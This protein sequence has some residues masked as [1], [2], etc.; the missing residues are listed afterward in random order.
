MTIKAIETLYHG[1]KFRSRLEARW[2]VFFGSLGAR[3]QYEPQGFL[4]DGIPYLPDFWIPLIGSWAGP[5][6][7]G[8]PPEKGFW[9]EIKPT[10]P[11]EEELRL[12][13]LLSRGTGHCVYLVAGQV[14]RGEFCS[15]K[16]HRSREEPF[17]SEY[18]TDE[19]YY[20]RDLSPSFIFYLVC[21]ASPPDAFAPDRIEAAYTAAR[22]AR[23]EHGETPG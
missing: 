16:F 1:C 20:L 7:E 12:C 19:P 2:A 14:G 21:E 18:K 15:Y 6:P 11:T 3:W 8:N 17:L 4:L 5:Y 10:T 23:F 13:R 9:V 22:S